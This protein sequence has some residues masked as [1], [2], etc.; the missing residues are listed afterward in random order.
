DR[1]AAAAR[2]ATKA[3]AADATGPATATDQHVADL[4]PSDELLELGQRRRRITAIEAANGHY[5]LAAGDDDGGRRLR[6]E[7]GDEVGRIALGGFGER[8]ER[9]AVRRRG[10]AEAITTT[11]TLSTTNERPSDAGRAG[12]DEGAASRVP[13]RC[14]RIRRRPRQQRRRTHDGRHT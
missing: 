11:T 2:T 10:A 9:T 1:R 4:A 7:R 3:A 6:S 5:R 13:N 8:D 12:A 14:Q